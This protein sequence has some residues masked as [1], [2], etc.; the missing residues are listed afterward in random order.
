MGTKI[1]KCHDK[2]MTRR[3]NYTDSYD[4]SLCRGAESED[5]RYNAHTDTHM[6]IQWD[7]TRAGINIWGLCA[8][9]SEAA[10]RCCVCNIFL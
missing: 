10:N 8:A 7:L 5:W 3:L 1:N 2:I 6:P 4:S 9:F